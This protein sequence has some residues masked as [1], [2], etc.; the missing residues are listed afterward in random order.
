MVP[1]VLA[2]RVLMEGQISRRGAAPWLRMD[3]K[4]LDGTR[5]TT[6]SRSGKGVNMPAAGIAMA[7][8]PV[9]S[10]SVQARAMTG[11]GRGM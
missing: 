6:E 10:G 7:R 3:G 8:T 5:A 4:M 1:G 9:R 11:I 2:T